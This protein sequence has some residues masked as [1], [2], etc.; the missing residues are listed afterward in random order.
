MRKILLLLTIPVL[1]L[2][3]ISCNIFNNNSPSVFTF[4]TNISPSQGGNVSPAKGEYEEKMALEITAEPME[5]YRF[6]RW[7]GDNTGSENPVTITFDSHKDITAVFVRKEYALTVN[8]DGEGSVGEEVIE[9]TAKTD[10]EHGTTVE[11]K[12]EPVE[13]WQFV[14]WQGDL[15]GTT[16]PETIHVEDENSVTA[17]FERIEYALNIDVQGEGDVILD[18]DEDSFY[19]GDD[20]TL[21]ARGFESWRFL[22]WQGD[23][24][25]TDTVAVIQDIQRD[26]DITAI[27]VP[28]EDPLWG[29]GYNHNGQLGDGSQTE[30]HSPVRNIYN[31][32][33]VTA[34]AFHSLFIKTDQTLWA[35]GYNLYGQIGNGTNTDP[36]IPVQVDS[37]VS[38]VAAGEHHSLIIKTDGTL[39]AM[40]QN[41]DGQLGDGTTTDRWAPVQIDSDVLEVAAGA[42]HSL[43]IK[44]DGSLWAM[45]RNNFGQLGDGSTGNK[46]GPVQI[47]SDV[48]TIAGGKRHSLFIKSDGSLY[49]MGRNAAGQLGVGENS[50]SNLPPDDQFTPVLIDTDVETIAGG[51]DHSLFTKTDGTLWTVGNNEFGQLGDG[52]T[53]SKANPVQIASDVIKVSAG[54]RHSLFLKTD[55]SLHAM[56]NNANGQ[57]GDGSTTNRH[58][59]VHIDDNISAIT[60]GINHSLYI[61]D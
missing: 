8:V 38:K 28:V 59:P 27:F 18:P 4:S 51:T 24:E 13:G 34:G 36:H 17:V 42:W 33:E 10:Y 60:A 53:S 39:W 30:Q 44:S 7:E 25:G 47:D 19:F 20:V 52:S 35:M 61:Q 54:N 45:G 22:E 3:S 58:S 15:S 29:M 26:Q 12:A 56:G 11:L 16:N 55:G 21:I 40:G 1:M 46:I 6:D 37:E 23:A 50:N 14:E 49:G 31:V 41:E 48:E 57:L 9:A 5:G 2:L 43:Y 32:E